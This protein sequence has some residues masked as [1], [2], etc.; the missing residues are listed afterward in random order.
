[1]DPFPPVTRAQWEKA[2]TKALEGGPGAARWR[3]AVDE[4]VTV[5][6]LHTERPAGE[7]PPPPRGD[8]RAPGGAPWNMPVRE[9]RSVEALAR[10]VEDDARGGIRAWRLER[11]PGGPET[12]AD[13]AR[14]L[15]AAPADALLA[16]DAGADALPAAAVAEAARRRAGR[17]AAWRAIDAADPF[18]AWATDGTLPRSL[19]ALDREAVA[20]V[21]GAAERGGRATLEVSTLPYHLAGARPAQEIGLA[22]AAGL[23]RYRALTDGGIAPDD[24]AAAIGFSVSIGRGLFPGIAKL[25]ALRAAW[26]RVLAAHGVAAGPAW[27]HARTSTRTLTARDPWVNLLRVTG[28]AFAAVAGRADAISCAAY[29]ELLDDEGSAGP[30]LARNTLPI[31][32]DECYAG[33]VADPARGSYLVESLTNDIAR[34]AWSHL[35]GIERHGG[36]AAA[37]ANGAVRESLAESRRIRAEAAE[38]GAAPITGV[39]AYANANEVPP[40]LRAAPA[41]PSARAG[42]AA[43]DAAPVT[44]PADPSALFG[45]LVAAAAAGAGVASLSAALAAAD[46]GPPA[47][48]IEPLPHIRDAAPFEE[49]AREVSS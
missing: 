36:L 2:A 41:S 37:L 1:M 10:A 44:V 19:A 21:R 24:A 6:P 15:A 17:D 49:P 32:L 4:G 16:W 34:A 18:A 14:A 11:T 27:V 23:T 35:R 12:A 45:A 28:Q 13:L 43:P 42:H 48:A 30:R 47:P 29:D 40:K 25:R 46:H 38:S 8:A 3:R 31:L 22:L 26:S 33:D 5:L 20:M 9:A 7:A 39:T